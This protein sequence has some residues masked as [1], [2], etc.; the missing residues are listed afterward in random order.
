MNSSNESG[1]EWMLTNCSAI[2]PLFNKHFM[3]PSLFRNLFLKTI[4]VISLLKI[5]T[6]SD[7]TM[8]K[9]L[10]IASFFIFVF[11]AGCPDSNTNSSI[12]KSDI[13]YEKPETAKEV[14]EGY[15]VE[16]ELWYNGK[17]WD[18]YRK[19][20]SG[21]DNAETKL[22]TISR[23]LTNASNDVFVSM[24]ETWE[25]MSFGESFKHYAKWIRSN[26]GQILDK[27]I[28]NVNGNDVL[29]IK[30]NLKVEPEP[31]T[32][33]MYVLTTKS[34]GVSVTAATAEHLFE[35]YEKEM[36]DLLNGLVDPNTNARSK[37]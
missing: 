4:Q 20:V 36:V 5:K 8:S 24:E 34:G 14:I 32:S 17:E 29:F 13:R 16:Y 35:R 23:V 26:K 11:I 3:N 22:K 19:E 37:E 31:L 18:F 7:N 6:E 15:A 10:Y 1:M 27:H 21:G 12:Q 2:R 33:V 9:I 25:K 28:R 30:S